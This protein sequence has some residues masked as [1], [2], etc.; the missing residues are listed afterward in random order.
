MSSVRRIQS[1]RRAGQS[2]QATSAPPP[3]IGEPAMLDVTVVLL[4][5]GFPSTA[6]GPIEIFHAAGMLWNKLHGTAHQPRFRVRVA[7][8]DGES[9][10]SICSMSITP[11]FSI[12]DIARSDIVIL[13]AASCDAQMRIVRETS[14]VPWLR[15][16]HA[17][18]AYIG[19]VCTSALFLAESGLLD[20]R[21]ATTHWGVAEGL[22]QRYPK[23]RWRPDLFVTEDDRILCSGGVYASFDLSLYLVEK[24]CGHEIAV[25]CAKSLLISMPR[26]RQSGY[27]VIPLSRPHTDERIRQIEEYLQQHFV[28]DVS[29]GVLA[30][31]AAMSPRNFIRRFR[32]ATGRL[33]GAYIQLLRVSAAKEMLENGTASIQ[34]ICS[35]IGYE[36]IAFF[37][38]LFKRH[39]GAT[40][41]EYRRRFARVSF[42]RGELEAGRTVA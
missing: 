23:V 20:G 25:Q 40:P 10:A 22:Q 35:A 39:T 41:T 17:Q 2:A 16:V 21:Q 24:F 19:A 31:I 27:A 36:D 29:I 13:A 14:L 4:D 6:I 26:S 33:P 3:P 9:V 42:E 30:D 38:N 1:A 37:R 11:Q 28:G 34:E 8:V 7:S 18:G 32:A 5:G 15:K 12:H